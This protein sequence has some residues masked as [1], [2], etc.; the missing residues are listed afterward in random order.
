MDFIQNAKKIEA[1]LVK[2]DW[3][4]KR[5]VVYVSQIQQQQTTLQQQAGEL[6]AYKVQNGKLAGEL[7]T[8]KQQTGEQALKTNQA[9]LEVWA[10]RVAVVLY[11]ASKIK[12]ILP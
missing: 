9:R 7:A 1:D 10:M 11:I 6:A 3:A 4:I 2:G 5:E 12:G 8:S